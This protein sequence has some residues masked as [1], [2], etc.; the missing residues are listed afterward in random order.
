MVENPY[1]IMI[2]EN[3]K[4]VVE[5]DAYCRQQDKLVGRYVQE[6]YA[7]GY[8]YYEIVRENKKSVRLRV[9]QN[10]GDDWVLPYWGEEYTATKEYVLNS[11]AHRDRIEELHSLRK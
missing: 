3:W 10:I 1:L 5:R 8:A 2:D 6:P 11:L 9:I 4:K 7:D